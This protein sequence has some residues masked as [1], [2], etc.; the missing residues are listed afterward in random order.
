MLPQTTS[1]LF[2]TFNTYTFLLALG[3]MISFAISALTYRLNY[4]SGIGAVIDACLA[5]LLGG[6]VLGRVGH[7]LIHW[8]Y[9]S[10]H[11]DEIIR[12]NA[13]GL[14][15]HSALIGI[16]WG[17]GL[18]KSLVHRRLNTHLI[19]ESWAWAIPLLGWMGWWACSAFYCGYGTEINNLTDYPPTLVWEAPAIN[20][21]MA[22]RFATQPLGMLYGA[23]LM[24][25]LILCSRRG[26]LK[27][28]RFGVSL[29]LWSI[30][31]FLL[32]YLRGDNVPRIADIRVDQ[33]LDI[34]TLIIG[35]VYIFR[36]RHYFMIRAD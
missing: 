8:T 2:F 22:P 12:I 11:T 31:M 28:K 16:F 23:I 35:G 9:F 36:N 3:I 7:V 19:I 30:G 5:G 25:F 24:L 29:M 1:F 18:M 14:N 34:L 15:W 17:F 21:M 6:V 26:W 4:T 20:G 32:G 33:W 27:G 13:G 10:E